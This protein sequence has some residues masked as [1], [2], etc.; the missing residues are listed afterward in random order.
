MEG[1]DGRIAN[2]KAFLH[3][4]NGEVELT[5]EF[6]SACAL[7]IFDII[8]NIDAHESHCA[9]YGPLIEII[10]ERKR[11]VKEQ[12]QENYISEMRQ[13]PQNLF[14][15]LFDAFEDFDSQ[16]EELKTR[17]EESTQQLYQLKFYSMMA[18][19]VL[20][21]QRQAVRNKIRKT[22]LESSSNVMSSN[23]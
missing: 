22:Q 13:V 18:I 15:N 9:N 5:D 16:I 7:K 3:T 23:Y 10:I 4:Q 11:N 12:F 17:Y 6:Y 21:H 19:K 2:L 1:H 14:D 20:Y 8:D